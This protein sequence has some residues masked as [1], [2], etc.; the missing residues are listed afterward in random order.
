M[1][2][3]QLFSYMGEDLIIRIRGGHQQALTLEGIFK[4]LAWQKD[5]GNEPVFINH[6]RGHGG[7]KMVVPAGRPNI[8]CMTLVP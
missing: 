5:Q 4:P 2:C 1:L 7:L 3:F 8:A 6:G